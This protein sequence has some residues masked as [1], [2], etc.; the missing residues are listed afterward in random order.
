MGCSLDLSVY[1]EESLPEGS[2]WHGPVMSGDRGSLDDVCFSSQQNLKQ[3][4]SISTFSR[5][6]GVSYV[7]QREL[8]YHLGGNTKLVFLRSGWWL[9]SPLI[10]YLPTVSNSTK[11]Y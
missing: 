3:T 10:R 1:S 11:P 2:V 6:I 9:D 8:E 4:K 5:G 7:T